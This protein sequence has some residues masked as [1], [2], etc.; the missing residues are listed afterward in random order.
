MGD[1][2]RLQRLRRLTRPACGDKARVGYHENFG[3]AKV[4]GIPSDEA[5]R[6]SAKDNF[7]CDKFSQFEQLLPV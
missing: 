2:G 5:Q 3:G 7:R 1:A 6:T 4:L